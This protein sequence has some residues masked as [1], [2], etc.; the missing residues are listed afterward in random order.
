MN[1]YYMLYFDA[2]L[3][4]SLVSFVLFFFLQVYIIYDYY[5]NRI[6][7]IQ[8]IYAGDLILV[9]Y[10]LHICTGRND[11]KNAIKNIPILIS[12]ASSIYKFNSLF[13]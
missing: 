8:F 3:Q 12:K 5:L 10:D 9:T 1:G 4:E 6:I 11:N 7:R 13:T 2:L